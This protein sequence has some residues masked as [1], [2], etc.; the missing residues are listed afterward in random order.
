MKLRAVMAMTGT[1]GLRGDVRRPQT[2]LTDYPR[3]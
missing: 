2:R 1:A 3:Q